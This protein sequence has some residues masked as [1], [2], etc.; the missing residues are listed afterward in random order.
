[1]PSSL[2]SHYVRRGGGRQYRRRQTGQGIFTILG[3][4]APLIL[5]GIRHVVPI[6]TRAVARGAAQAGRH[7]HR[8]KPVVKAV[9]KAAKKASKVSGRRSQQLKTMRRRTK[10]MRKMAEEM[11]S[12]FAPDSGGDARS[13]PVPVP[14]TTRIKTSPL[15]SPSVPLPPTTRIKTSP[16]NSKRRMSSSIHDLVRQHRQ[17]QA[18]LQLASRVRAIRANI[19]RRAKKAARERLRKAKKEEEKEKKRRG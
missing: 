3:I 8:L 11:H 12:N 16:L 7:A 4:L 5:R 6:V 10:M 15:R 9:A 18:H 1:M 14:P 19:R 17:M 13:P 2:P